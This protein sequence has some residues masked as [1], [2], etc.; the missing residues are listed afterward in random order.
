MPY[1]TRR[2]V[3]C[4]D[5]PAEVE[6]EKP[7]PW[8]IPTGWASGVVH[9]ITLGEGYTSVSIKQVIRCDACLAVCGPILD[10]ELEKADAYFK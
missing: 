4:D 8:V 2:Y 10:P 5:C 3:V 1:V 7:G 6:V 9:S